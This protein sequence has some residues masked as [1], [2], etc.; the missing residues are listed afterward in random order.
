MTTKISDFRKAQ[1]K[2]KLRSIRISASSE[3]DDWNWRLSAWSEIFATF[4]ISAIAGILLKSQEFNFF[5]YSSCRD[6][7]YLQK[8][9]D[10][11][12]GSEYMREI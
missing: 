9:S 5:Q 2:R 6:I 7:E 1:K 12:F 11:L 4:I 3:S 8:N 10:I